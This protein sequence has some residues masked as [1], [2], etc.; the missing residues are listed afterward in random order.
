MERRGLHGD[1]IAKW[2]WMQMG[3]V[4]GV[5][6]RLRAALGGSHP[7]I[8]SGKRNWAELANISLARSLQ[9]PLQGLA[10]SAGALTNQRGSVLRVRFGP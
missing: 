10:V 1:P 9:V 8:F 7:S 2:S 6:R 5:P 3:H 4:A